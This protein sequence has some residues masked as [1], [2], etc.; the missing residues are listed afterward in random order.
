MSQ[1]AKMKEDLDK[2][3]EEISNLLESKLKEYEGLKNLYVIN[4]FNRIVNI[5]TQIHIFK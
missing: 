4:T 1:R 5:G 3:K 2:S